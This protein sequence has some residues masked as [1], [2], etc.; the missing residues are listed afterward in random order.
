MEEREKRADAREHIHHFVELKF[1]HQKRG[2]LPQLAVLEHDGR[3]FDGEHRQITRQAERH[4]HIGLIQAFV[5]TQVDGVHANS[6]HLFRKN[7]P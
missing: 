5:Q 7:F 3:V 2:N 1:K 6:Q 4:F